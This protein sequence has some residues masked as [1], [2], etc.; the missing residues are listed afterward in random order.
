[1]I[2]NGTALVPR[3]HACRKALELYR[4]LAQKSSFINTVKLN[5]YQK[6]IL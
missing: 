2:L 3:S 5:R 6:T 4:G 1:M